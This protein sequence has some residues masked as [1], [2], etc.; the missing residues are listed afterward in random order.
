MISMMHTQRYL[1]ELFNV[2]Y[3]MHNFLGILLF[4]YIFINVSIWRVSFW[5]ILQVLVLI[6]LLI[7]SYL[8]TSISFHILY[9]IYPRLE[10]K[11]KS[12]LCR[13]QIIV[14]VNGI[15]ICVYAFFIPYPH[16]TNN[17]MHAN[18]LWRRKSSFLLE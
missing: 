3:F 4:V 1:T 11:W 15:E 12:I 8:S 10:I 2:L 9:Q 7:S 6:H 17:Q 13:R 5:N 16:Y 14:P 18:L